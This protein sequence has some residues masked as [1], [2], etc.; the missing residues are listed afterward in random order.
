M[1]GLQGRS[2]ALISRARSR[3]PEPKS[4]FCWLFFL[5][6]FGEPLRGAV[7]IVYPDVSE[8]FREAFKQIVAGIEKT[9]SQPIRTNVLPKEATDRDFQEMLDG[10]EGDTVVLLGQRAFRFYERQTARRGPVFVSGI[11]ALPGQTAYPGVSLAT[12]PDLTLTA[13]RALLPA[14][15]NV[16]VYYNARDKPWI[17]RIKA[18]ASQAGLAVEAVP[19]RDAFEMARSLGETFKRLEPKTAA[20]WF[21]RDTIAFDTELLYPYVLEQS[22]DRGIAV[23]SDTIAHVRRGFLFAYYPNYAGIGAEVGQIILRAS[24]GERSGLQW[25]RAAELTLNARTAKHLGVTV[26]SGFMQQ[27]R[28]VF[29]AR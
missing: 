25:S 3:K 10:A 26:P 29:P 22:W 18:L 4:L 28:P 7:L 17:E 20:L 13:L 5:F 15:Q 14:L 19:V 9:L 12:D 16:V 27:A 11:D 24:E 2:H 1:T 8:P 21:G 23:V 6:F